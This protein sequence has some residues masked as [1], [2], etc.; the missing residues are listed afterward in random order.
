MMKIT[1]KFLSLLVLFC[2]FLDTHL[3]AQEI[4]KTTGIPTNSSE[5][6]LR[7]KGL[8]DE[9]LCSRIKETLGEYKSKILSFSID[10]N[11]NLLTVVI[12]D[13][14]QKKDL[15]EILQLSNI[16]AGYLLDHNR[17]VFLDDDGELTDPREM[18][19]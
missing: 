6:L 4:Q 12:S 8:R 9:T 1:G 10:K 5:V 2:F 17:Y 11:T 7:I 13:R 16:H 18:K 3:I 14:L 15:L 19:E